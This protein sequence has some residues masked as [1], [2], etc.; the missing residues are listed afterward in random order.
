MIWK[1]LKAFRSVIEETNEISAQNVNRKA[2]ERF[3]Y[4]FVQFK[5]SLGMECKQSES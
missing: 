3:N 4:I 5:Q 1:F 2:N